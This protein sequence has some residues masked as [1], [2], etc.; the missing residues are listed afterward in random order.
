MVVYVVAVVVCMGMKMCECVFCS[1]SL[2]FWLAHDK[3]HLLRCGELISGCQWLPRGGGCRGDFK[4]SC[5]SRRRRRCC[6][7]STSSE[8]LSRSAWGTKALPLTGVWRW[9]WIIC[10]CLLICLSPSPRHW[11]CYNLRMKKSDMYPEEGK[12]NRNKNEMKI[13]TITIICCTIIYYYVM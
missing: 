9:W 2:S 8:K 4:H 1:Y 12:T 5:R 3:Y 7:F 6:L 10:A 13:F 11:Q